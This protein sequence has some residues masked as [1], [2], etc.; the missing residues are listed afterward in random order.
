MA[1]L[2]STRVHRAQQRPHDRSPGLPDRLPVPSLR[3]ERA[4]LDARL[5]LEYVVEEAVE[6]AFSSHPKSLTIRVGFA[7]IAVDR[8][9]E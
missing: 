4:L 2:G 9:D 7:A 3:S 1:E 5:E 8:P 6:P